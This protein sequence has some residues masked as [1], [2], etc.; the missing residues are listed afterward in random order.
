MSYTIK[1]AIQLLKLVNLIFED[2]QL[3]KF[4]QE[5]E[6]SYEYLNEPDLPESIN[7]LLNTLIIYAQVKKPDDDKYAEELAT[8]YYDKLVRIGYLKRL[9]LGDKLFLDPFYARL[10]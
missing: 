8:E 9:V 5:Y 4:I 3:E 6:S 7:F 1:E 2:G 10:N